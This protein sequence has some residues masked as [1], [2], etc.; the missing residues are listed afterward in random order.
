MTAKFNWGG[1]GA[2][3]GRMKR[4]EIMLPVT[5]AGM[6]DYKYMEQYTKNMM[7]KKYEQYLAFID[8]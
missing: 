1:N 4:L 6:P 3:L 5:D 2:T 7:L 8:R